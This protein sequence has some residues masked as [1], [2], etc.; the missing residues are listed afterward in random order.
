MARRSG[1][2]PRNLTAG[3]ILQDGSRPHA[4]LAGNALLA[5]RFAD[6]VR[7][8]ESRVTNAVGIRRATFTL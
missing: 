4:A 5:E 3:T 7:S 2:C 8:Y 1:P 6:K